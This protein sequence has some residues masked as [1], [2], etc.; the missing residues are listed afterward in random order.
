ME[1]TL[2]DPRGYAPKRSNQAR[3]E[4]RLRR[5]IVGRFPFFRHPDNHPSR[6]WNSW[7]DTPTRPPFYPI[8]KDEVKARWGREWEVGSLKC[9]V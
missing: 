5:T 3:N 8:G 2:P 7:P 6:P 4:A 1:P 9:E